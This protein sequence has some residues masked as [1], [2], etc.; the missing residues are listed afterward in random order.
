MYDFPLLA[1]QPGAPPIGLAVL[2]VNCAGDRNWPSLLQS[3][4]G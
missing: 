3:V 4:N 1:E 2:G